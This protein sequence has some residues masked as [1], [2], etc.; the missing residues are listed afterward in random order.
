MPT[1]VSTRG[2][3]AE[4]AGLYA[5][6]EIAEEAADA[7]LDRILGWIPDN[8][9]DAIRLLELGYVRDLDSHVPENVLA[10]LRIIVGA[11]A[12]PPRGRAG[13]SAIAASSGCSASGRP[14]AMPSQMIAM[15]RPSWPRSLAFRVIEKAIAD[16]PADG[17]IGLAVKFC[18]G[19]WKDG[20]SFGEITR[21]TLR[22]AARFV[23]E[24]APLCTQVLEEDE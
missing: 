19:L 14:R 20:T 5:E 10:G 3:P 9:A 16:T 24:L 21:S 23:P 11:A 7:H 22:D 2:A 13:H 17:V 6:A 8:L 15:I 12:M 1:L 4:I 18:L